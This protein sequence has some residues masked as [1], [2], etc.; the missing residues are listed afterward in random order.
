MNVT[1][2]GYYSTNYLD[3]RRKVHN[4]NQSQSQK[5]VNDIFVKHD[6]Q[7]EEKEEPKKFGRIFGRRANKGVP[8]TL[9]RIR[10]SSLEKSFSGD[11][12]SD[13][14]SSDGKS[15]RTNSE[16]AT[17]FTNDP[18]YLEEEITPA[19]LNIM[20]KY[21]SQGKKKKRFL[22]DGVFE[23][24]GFSGYYINQKKK[25]DT[26]PIEMKNYTHR[27]FKEVFKDN[28]FSDRYNPAECVF[29]N[30]KEPTLKNKLKALNL[31]IG[32]DR[33]K[34][35]DYYDNLNIKSPQSEHGTYDM[36]ELG[37]MQSYGRGSGLVIAEPTVI[38]PDD[39]ESPK[40]EEIKN[41]EEYS[42]YY[43]IWTLLGTAL[44][45]ISGVE[46]S[47]PKLLNE[48]ISSSE[49]NSLVVQGQGS[50]SKSKDFEKGLKAFKNY[51][52]IVSKWNKPVS[53]IWKDPKGPIQNTP[54]V[55]EEFII[56]LDDERDDDEIDEELYYDQKTGQLVKLPPG[57][58][59][60]Q[61]SLTQLRLNPGGGVLSHFCQLIKTIKIM[62]LI[63]TPIDIIG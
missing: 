4:R 29:N 40:I 13:G 41:N 26:T 56:E 20:Q 60:N 58:R 47:L 6:E 35:Y 33:Y 2:N 9:K 36:M 24:N 37:S 23:S 59:S 32:R 5:T 28:D 31:K 22:P 7:V 48:S 51:K 43:S 25:N 38:E 10:V 21:R 30:E 12:S 52:G 14:K 27:T 18:D 15:S 54:Y 1:D 11:Q 55:Q 19:D 50:G 8:Y 16:Y 3:S 45:Y 61:N 17:E 39:E 42:N 62:K 63:F 53:V 49:N 46:N 57:M 34:N 44:S